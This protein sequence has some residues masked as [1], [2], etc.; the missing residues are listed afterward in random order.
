[1][2]LTVVVAYNRTERTNSGTPMEPHFMVPV[3]PNSQFVGRTEQLQLLE[4]FLSAQ[5]YDMCSA[6]P[7]VA[8]HGLGGVG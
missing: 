3:S 6:Y 5:E 7:V 4:D 2:I 1:M 8:V